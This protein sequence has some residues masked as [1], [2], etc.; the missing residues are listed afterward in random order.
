MLLV[1]PRGDD[2]VRLQQLEPRR[3][4]IRRNAWEALLQLLE[5]LCLLLIMYGV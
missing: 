3:Q 1:E 5:A 4:G 2:A